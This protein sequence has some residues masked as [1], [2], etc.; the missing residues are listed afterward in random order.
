MYTYKT[1]LPGAV[2]KKTFFE[3]NPK[4]PFL[5]KS[6]HESSESFQLVEVFQ[7]QIYTPAIDKQQNKFISEILVSRFPYYPVAVNRQ[8][9]LMRIIYTTKKISSHG[10]TAN[11]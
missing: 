4:T 3:T 2:Q 1:L 6:R 7:V 8:Q 11:Q 9:V 5:K 10:V